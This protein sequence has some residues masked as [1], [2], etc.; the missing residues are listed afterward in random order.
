[1]ASAAAAAAAA[2][3]LPSCCTSASSMATAFMSTPAAVAAALSV[4]MRTCPPS[5]P[6]GL[7]L[8]PFGSG[9]A[10]PSRN[11]I[12][13]LL[14]P[15]SSSQWLPRRHERDASGAHRSRPP[16]ALYSIRRD[17]FSPAHSKA[18]PTVPSWS[19]SSSSRGR[20]SGGSPDGDNRH[21]SQN[22]LAGAG[23][24]LQPR[25]CRR[26][27]RSTRLAGLRKPRDAGG[28]ASAGENPDRNAEDGGEAGSSGG[29]KKGFASSVPASKRGPPEDDDIWSKHSVFEFKSLN[30]PDTNACGY[31]G[32]SGQPR[33]PS[34]S[35]SP[36]SSRGPA[37]ELRLTSSQQPHAS[38]DG[39]EE[40]LEAERPAANGA[41]GIDA[42]FFKFR[43]KEAL[44]SVERRQEVER[45]R[46]TAGGR[47]GGGGGRRGGASTDD[48]SPVKIE[49]ATQLGLPATSTYDE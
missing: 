20:G 37:P 41:P 22:R 35:S 10:R 17:L 49:L 42:D 16:T 18:K 5:L 28:P 12:D 7:A 27:R 4:R 43:E 46:R 45:R 36:S 26:R 40:L 25:L 9:V 44:A 14:F 23:D 19:S 31:K 32:L 2:V 34:S 15:A 39:V 30:D 21:F 3:A 1:M 11:G 48:R 33:A 38:F 13:G 6:L 29:T 47:G 8:P 24:D